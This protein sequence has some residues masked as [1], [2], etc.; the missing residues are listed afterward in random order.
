MCPKC[1]EIESEMSIY[2]VFIFCITYLKNTSDKFNP[3]TYLTATKIL[4][5]YPVSCCSNYTHVVSNTIYT[6]IPFLFRFIYNNKNC[7]TK[8]CMVGCSIQNFVLLQ[9]RSNQAFDSW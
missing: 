1:C 6:G 4:L 7:F 5:V 3:V 9:F 2:G 8:C